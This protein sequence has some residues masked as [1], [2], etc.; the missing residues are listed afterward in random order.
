MAFHFLREIQPKS[1]V[2]NTAGMV[3]HDHEI[4]AEYVKTINIRVHKVPWSYVVSK[5]W[6]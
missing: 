6:Y 5:K 4:L 3:T 1:F 2:I